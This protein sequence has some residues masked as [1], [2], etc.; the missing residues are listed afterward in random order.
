MNSYNT[1]GGGF[2][3]NTPAIT[4]NLIIINV[5][6][7]IATMAFGES[8][9]IYTLG[10][11]YPDSPFFEPYQVVT[12]MFMHGGFNH[13]LFNM[14]ALWM[15]G[16]VLER[17]WGP[18]RFLFYYL[19]CALG[20]FA[21]HMGVQAWEV[22]NITGHLHNDLGIELTGDGYIR[23]HQNISQTVFSI[24]TTPV[25]G[26]SGAIFGLLLGYGMYY[27]N[28][29]LYLMFIP[30]PIKAKWFVTVYGIIE[31]MMGLNNNPGDSVAH[32]AHLGGM[33]FG[34]ILIKAWK[35]IDLNSRWQ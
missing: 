30:V 21:L 28:H 35:N 4:K 10:A 13:I 34:F 20:A 2:M 7:F 3:S 19:F 8:F 22:F 29:S 32:F 1:S 26:A 23:H 9:M 25:V 6:F 11:F 16:S 5:V 27:P 14:F 12:H 24:Y 17:R 33:L 31:L 15:F 18:K